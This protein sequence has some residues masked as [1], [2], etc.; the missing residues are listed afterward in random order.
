MASSS[1]NLTFIAF[2]LSSNYAVG[3]E[4]VGGLFLLYFHCSSL[5]SQTSFNP[6]NCQSWQDTRALPVLWRNS[7]YLWSVPAGLVAPVSVCEMWGQT[8][9]EMR[10]GWKAVTATTVAMIYGGIV[11]EGLWWP[12]Q[13]LLCS[14]VTLA[15]VKV[16]SG[17][18]QNDHRQYKSCNNSNHAI[19]RAPVISVKAFNGPALYIL[20]SHLLSIEPYGTL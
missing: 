1:L 15:K 17:V 19:S 6:G 8:E 2:F 11:I 13:E 5:S 14:Q 20:P 7:R 4:F 12:C 9:R 10:N 18:T 3:V 16:L